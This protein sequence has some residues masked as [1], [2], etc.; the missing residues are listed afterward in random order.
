MNVELTI[1]KYYREWEWL[2]LSQLKNLYCK[3]LG[4]EDYLLAVVY[5]LQKF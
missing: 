4:E 5:I 3:I 2:F 1:Q